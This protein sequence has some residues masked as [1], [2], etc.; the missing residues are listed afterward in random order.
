MV[1]KVIAAALTLVCLGVTLLIDREE[2]V[3]KLNEIRSGSSRSN[4]T[5]TDRYDR[6]YTAGTAEDRPSADTPGSGLP[7][8]NT[9]KDYDPVE[10]DLVNMTDMDEY[11]K[12]GIPLTDNGMYI[13][14]H[15]EVMLT[16][17]KIGTIDLVAYD[18]EEKDGKRYFSGHNYTHSFLKDTGGVKHPQE[19]DSDVRDCLSFRAEGPF[20]LKFDDYNDDGNADYVLR[21]SDPTDGGAYYVLDYTIADNYFDYGLHFYWS[22]IKTM[23]DS[24]FFVYGETDQ[25]IRFRHIDRDHFFFITRDEEG[26]RTVSIVDKEFGRYK[27]DDLFTDGRVWCAVYDEDGLRFDAVNR[28]TD[29]S[30]DYPDVG[31]YTGSAHVT[32]R[33][34]DGKV[35]R[36]TGYETVVTFSAKDD[37][38]SS[39]PVPYTC[40]KGEY[41]AELE[42]DDGKVVYV[43]WIVR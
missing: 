27:G 17:G 16:N 25:S 5:D 41:Q 34:L 37:M 42:L 12:D 9:V 24:A 7:G 29:R 2:I 8:T 35:W 28:W 33:E 30:G 23:A 26:R 1:R 31:V 32:V 15:N 3:G 6:D 22:D 18:M 20:K 38:I 4:Y 43:W 21:V 13:Y 36:K 11:Y 10:C 14:S 39:A 19:Y 40:R